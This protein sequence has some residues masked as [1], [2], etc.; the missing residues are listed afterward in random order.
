ME[1]WAYTRKGYELTINQGKKE[2]HTGKKYFRKITNYEYAVENKPRE[3]NIEQAQR[4]CFPVGEGGGGEGGAS[5]TTFM[6]RDVIR[7]GG[8]LFMVSALA[9]YRSHGR[10]FLP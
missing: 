10:N 2:A 5:L 3:M 8:A 4:T 6:D 7:A 9:L 1:I